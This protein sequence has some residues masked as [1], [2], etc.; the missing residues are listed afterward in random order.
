MLTRQLF[1]RIKGCLGTGIICTGLISAQAFCADS[2]LQEGKFAAVFEDY[3]AHTIEPNVPGYAAA[4]VTADGTHKITSGVRT[5]GVEAPFNESTVFRIA[6]V[7]KTFAPAAVVALQKPSLD[8][9]SK[10]ASFL[11]DLR[12]SDP[13]YLKKLTIGHVLSQ[14][15]GLVPHAYTNLIQDN[16][17]YSKIVKKLRDV[18]FICEPGSC[19]SY[20]NVVY[21]LAGDALAQA[22]D[23]SYEKIV[24]N[25][26]FRALA[27]KSSSFGLASLLAKENRATPHRWDN[28]KKR[29]QA[30]QPK[31]NYYQLSPSAG[32]NTN[33][34]DMI[35]WLE[36]QLGRHPDILSDADLKKMHSPRVKVTRR[37]SS[38][39]E[40]ASNFSYALGWR[41][42]DFN[43]EQG[44]VYH[45]GWVEGFRVEMVF[46]RRLN[47]GLFFVTNSESRLANDIVPQ[48]VR[49]YLQYA[50]K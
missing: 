34:N 45:G 17:P 30:T 9:D 44:F 43:E 13:A 14:A 46:N 3:L 7:S 32:I 24:E 2:D 4:I 8:F 15:S 11:P 39:W 18:D 27:M 48:F 40:G 21:N 29:W 50:S 12:L 26:L 16:V 37:P 47:I 33:L 20:Q 49:M 5:V 31:A 25:K 28:K 41:T 6:S 36:A 23:S 10:L 1:L 19:Y 38:R 35:R 22:G 42:F